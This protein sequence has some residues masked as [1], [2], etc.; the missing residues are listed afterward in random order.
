MLVWALYVLYRRQRPP[1]CA[2]SVWVCCETDSHSQ[3]RL[4]VPPPCESV[5]QRIHILIDLPTWQIS[6]FGSLTVSGPCTTS[7]SFVLRTVC[8]HVSGAAA[9]LLTVPCDCSMVS[10]TLAASG[11]AAQLPSCS[12]SIPRQ[13]LW[14]A[15][16]ASTRPKHCTSNHLH[17][18]RTMVQGQ[19]SLPES[20]VLVTPRQHRS[21]PSSAS[22][23]WSS[24]SR[25]CWFGLSAWSQ[26]I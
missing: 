2:A 25:R 24:P 16:P 13:G 23:V 15:W 7:T 26:R 19:T 22:V 11:R 5:A 3:C 14:N 1:P 4:R 20:L 9:L 6:T 8:C 10:T 17:H 12:S 21:M 18:T